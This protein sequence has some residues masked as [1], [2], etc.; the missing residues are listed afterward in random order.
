MVFI[1]IMLL[2][3]GYWDIC[4]GHCILNEL[5]G[6]AYYINGEEIVYDSV[7]NTQFI[8]NLVTMSPNNEKLKSCLKIL[9]NV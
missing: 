3:L 5:G 1:W 4:S 8:K 7:D 2:G 6:G 9:E